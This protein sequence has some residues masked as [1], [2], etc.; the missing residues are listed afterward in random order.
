MIQALF[1]VLI[2][3]LSI[4]FGA[5]IAKNLFLQI[6]PELVSFLRITIAAGI[7]AVFFKPWKLRPSKSNW[8]LLIFYGV[9][10]GLMNLSFYKS[11][12]KIPLGVAVAVEFTGPLLLS[13]LFSRKAIDFV[14]IGLAACGLYLLSP[15]Y[16]EGVNQLD[17]MGLFWA[18]VAGL[19]WGI[20]IYFGG[21]VSKS[22]PS[23]I[24]SSWGMIIA[25]LA[26]LPWGIKSF[27]SQPLSL[28]L[29]GLAA[30]VAILSSALPYS[31]EMVAMKKIPPQNF[32]ILMSLEPVVATLS[33][34]LVLGEVL[35]FTQLLAIALV[36]F[37]SLGSVLGLK[38]N[39]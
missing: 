35:T 17:G 20:Y 9:S 32:G 8:R 23:A 21:K 3:M 13:I 30:L 39:H 4:Q 7:L 2:A 10:L 37:A 14:W 29:L 27:G 34:Y 12:E 24:A 16:T 36:I 18:L 6:G 22:L 26:V 15:F 11:L 5:S 1:F 38:K 31:L 28:N 33:G 25:A 19:F